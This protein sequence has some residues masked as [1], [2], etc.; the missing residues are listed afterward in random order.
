MASYDEQ[1][2]RALK[3]QFRQFDVDR[4]GMLDFAEVA[5]L[6]RHGNRGMTDD[7]VKVIFACVDRDGSGQV[8]F[9]E[10]IDFLFAPELGSSPLTSSKSKQSKSKSGDNEDEQL[11][12][13]ANS[14]EKSAKKCL[15]S[16]AKLRDLKR[17]ATLP[18]EKK[19]QISIFGASADDLN[20]VYEKPQR[21]W[22]VQ[23]SAGVDES[24]GVSTGGGRAIFENT[25]AKGKRRVLFFGETKKGQS[26]WFAANHLPDENEP[27]E[28]YIIFNPSPF[29]ETPDQCRAAWETP[30]GR[31]DKRLVCEPLTV[32]S[33]LEGGEADDCLPEELWEDDYGEPVDDEL[34]DEDAEDEEWNKEWAAEKGEDFG[35]NDD[36]DDDVKARRGKKG[37]GKKAEAEAEAEEDGQG[38]SDGEN[39]G[40]HQGDDGETKKK[41]SGTKKSQK[42]TGK[43]LIGGGAES[44]HVAPGFHIAA[45]TGP[46]DLEKARLE[47]ERQAKQDEADRARIQ[48][49]KDQQSANASKGGDGAKGEPHS[50]ASPKTGKDKSAKARKEDD[51]ALALPDHVDSDE[52]NMWRDSHFS[53]KKSSLGQVSGVKAKGW[54][55]LSKMHQKPCLFKAILPEDVVCAEDAGNLWFVSAVAAVAEY[56]AWV[57]SMFGRKTRLS[58]K[59]KYKIRLYHPGKQAFV[60]VTIDDYVPTIKKGGGPAFAGITGNGELWMP[61]VEKAFAKFCGSYENTE[62]GDTA[63][64]MVYLCGGSGA[65]I[66]KRVGSKGWKR[67]RTVWNDNGGDGTTIDRKQGES[68]VTDDVH[69]D[70]NQIWGTLRRHMEYCYPVLCGVQ[71]GKGNACGLL[72]DRMYSILGARE[73]RASDGKV[74]RLVLLRNPF[75]VGE[76]QGRWSDESEAWL[77]CPEVASY[78]NFKPGDDGT[79]WMSYRDFVKYFDT[80]NCVR[81]PMPVQGTA[82]PK[83]KGLKRGLGLLVE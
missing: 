8:L 25:S 71:K 76:W 48:K 21:D 30:K 45:S 82:T 17:Q 74:L 50:P 26:G 16:T 43:K 33:E 41:G 52:D 58:L 46:Q 55:R 77:E 79:F 7:Q 75:G 72:C 13:A 10:F 60:S 35:K 36:S 4:N 83:V 27:V 20:G 40:D 22:I 64:G 53:P 57:Q 39:K 1:A 78:L 34:V 56:P 15:G 31:R 5:A 11:E 14:I 51:D 70:V 68:I 37:K 62:W 23:A 61:L 67:S 63:W 49:R 24:K 12:F 38:G 81:K 18:K 9:D 54:G 3:A 65:E 66:W 32:G 59:G 44:L 28:E 19:Q 73:V 47:R 69:R 29:A 42:H 80:I 2:V 6:L